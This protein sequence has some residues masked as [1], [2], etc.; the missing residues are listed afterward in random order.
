VKHIGVVSLLSTTGADLPDTSFG[1]QFIDIEQ[2][3]A[4]LGVSYTF[5]RLPYFLEN[6]YGFKQSVEAQN[7]VYWG[8]NADVRFGF[9]ASEDAGNASAA[10]LVN[11]TQYSNQTLS[12]CS[13]SQSY[14]DVA[15]E[16]GSALGR[17][18][19]YVLTPIE[20]L[21]GVL[22]GMG[23]PEWQKR[24]MCEFM[25]AL[26]KAAP[27]IIEGDP[28]IYTK[29]TGENPTT[30]KAWIAKNVDFFK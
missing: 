26:N 24:G 9:I 4:S 27:E 16:L 2:H 21:K 6:I 14:S 23:L 12:L 5:V 11:P 17:E 3:I 1:Q 13:D 8:V 30:L 20:V 19:S 15:R 29:I 10:I 25:A 18:I 28:S 22:D 7:A